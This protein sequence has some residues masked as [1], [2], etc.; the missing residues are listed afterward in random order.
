MPKGT[1]VHSCVQELMAKG[2]DKKSAIKICQAS[3]GQSYKTG[4]KTNDKP[5]TDT[6]G[7][8]KVGRSKMV[9]AIEKNR[10]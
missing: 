4:E 8:S 3:T 6:P 5:K 2:H 7:S 9:S 10:G 1:K